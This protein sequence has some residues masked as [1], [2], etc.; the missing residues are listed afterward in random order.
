MSPKHSLHQPALGR[1]SRTGLIFLGS[2][3]LSAPAQTV[4]SPAQSPASPPTTPPARESKLD[5]PSYYRQDSTDHD[6][7]DFIRHVEYGLRRETANSQLVAAKA[8]RGA[9]REFAQRVVA[10][11]EE[12]GREL[13]RLAEKRKVKLAT[14][15]D[16]QRPVQTQLDPRAAN[17]EQVY[18][19]LMTQDHQRA[20]R[21]F[22]DAAEHSND[23]DVRAF[24]R[25]FLPVLRQ[26]LEHAQQTQAAA[27]R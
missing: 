27:A 2:V 7:R 8:D 12:I 11:Q 15:A 24:A 21:L 23:A 25:K 20:V 1:L 16:G 5:K 18:L 9:L 17:F 4:G 3:A 6:D 19:Q 22:S 26:H 13:S 10:T 14:T